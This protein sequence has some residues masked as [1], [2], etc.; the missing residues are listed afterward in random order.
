MSELIVYVDGFNLYHG[1]HDKYGRRLLWL[2]LVKLSQTLRPRDHLVKVKYFTASV[3]DD[4]E[5]LSRQ[6]AY[7]QALVAHGGSSIEIVKGRYQKKQ[8]QCRRCG[9]QWTHYE[10]KETDV[11]IAVSLVADVVTGAATSAMVISADSD[12]SPAI[13][14][15]QRLA[16]TTHIMAAFPPRRFSNELQKLMPASFSIGR[17]KFTGAQ[18][19][20]KVVDPETGHVIERPAKWA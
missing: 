14:T 11:N 16:P 18:L 7:L 9:S 19:P 4:P 20:E 6:D 10:E 13:R 15:A 8:K 3:L 5:A 1:L 17:A 12:L 2:D